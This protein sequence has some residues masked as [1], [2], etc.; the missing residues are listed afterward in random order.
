MQTQDSV[1]RRVR[2]VSVGAGSLAQSLRHLKR[3]T[4][5][6]GGREFPAGPSTGRAYFAVSERKHPSDVETESARH[7]SPISQ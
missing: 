3:W 7:S 5:A 4:G 1:W 2:R 6:E